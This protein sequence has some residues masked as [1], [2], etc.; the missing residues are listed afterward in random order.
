VE[1]GTT[2]WPTTGESNA[3]LDVPRFSAMTAAWARSWAPGFARMLPTGPLTASSVTD[4]RA[5][6]SLLEL[7]S[8]SRLEHAY[9]R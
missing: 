9:F 3:A 5:A 2:E 8:A 4:R 7:P 1:A 6:I